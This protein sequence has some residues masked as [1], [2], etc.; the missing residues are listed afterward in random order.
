MGD[1]VFLL[2][3]GVLFNTSLQLLQKYCAP[4]TG[5]EHLFI[6]PKHTQKIF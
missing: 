5:S 2:G 4:L 3:E 6:P 1:R